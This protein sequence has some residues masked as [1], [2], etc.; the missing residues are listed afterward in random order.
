MLKEWLLSKFIVLSEFINIFMNL[1]NLESLLLSE[2]INI[3]M[4]LV[5]LEHI[6]IVCM[7]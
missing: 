6:N 1:V 3:V 5:N 7:Y 4:N 2:F